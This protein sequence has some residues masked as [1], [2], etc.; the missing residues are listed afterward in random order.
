MILKKVNDMSGILSQ[1][2][3]FQL[4]LLPPKRS[5]VLSLKVDKVAF[6]WSVALERLLSELKT[7]DLDDLDHMK[8]T[9]KESANRGSHP[10]ATES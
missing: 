8:W 3:S 1:L 2:Q 6:L 4:G 10:K 5:R 7:E 9:K